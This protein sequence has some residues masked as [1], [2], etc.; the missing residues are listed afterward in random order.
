MWKK[1]NEWGRLL[2]LPIFSHFPCPAGGGGKYDRLDSRNHP[3]YSGTLLG[4]LWR[5]SGTPGQNPC[6]FQGCTSGPLKL[7]HCYPEVPPSGCPLVWA[8]GSFLASCHPEGWSLILYPHVKYS[9]STL[10]SLPLNIK[11]RNSPLLG[12]TKD[13]DC[14]PSHNQATA[15]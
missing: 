8:G 4:V 7:Q 3:Y 1:G 12:L 11:Y 15:L 13:P 5:Q 9:G 14:P 6:R 2:P 10:L